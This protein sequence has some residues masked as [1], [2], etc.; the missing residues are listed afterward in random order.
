MEA[1]TSK[2]A[3]EEVMLGNVDLKQEDGQDFE[4]IEVE[5]QGN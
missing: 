2:E 1:K 4:I 3:R 5:E